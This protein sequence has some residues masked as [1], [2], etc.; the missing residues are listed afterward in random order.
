MRII[1]R[2]DLDLDLLET[3][4]AKHL[5]GSELDE[6]KIATV[7]EILEWLATDV[8]ELDAGIA[9]TLVHVDAESALFVYD[10]GD[11]VAHLLVDEHEVGKT[12][13]ALTWA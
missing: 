13:F 8:E 3:A 7:V 12:I 5:A 2:E 11:F 6:A 1:G 4:E 10:F 9:E